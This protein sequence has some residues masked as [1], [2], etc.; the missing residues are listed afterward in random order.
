MLHRPSFTILPFKPEFFS[1][2][3]SMVTVIV[4]SDNAFM[5]NL[6]FGFGAAEIASSSSPSTTWATSTCHRWPRIS[7][8]LTT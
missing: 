8:S 6:D 3:N 2:N 1:S 5:S 4:P 7:S